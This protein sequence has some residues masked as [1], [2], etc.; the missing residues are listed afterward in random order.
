MVTRPVPLWRPC[1]SYARLDS[2][3]SGG[4]RRLRRRVLPGAGTILSC[5]RMVDGQGSALKWLIVESAYGLLRLPRVVEFDKGKPAR[6]PAFPLHREI[7]VRQWADCREMFPQLGF[8][9]LIG[10]IPHKQSNRHGASP[11]DPL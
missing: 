5:T 8:G 7:D 10:Q 3:V 4:Q 11:L 6:P 9:G 2:A 1:F